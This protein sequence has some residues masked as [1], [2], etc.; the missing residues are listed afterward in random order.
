MKEILLKLIDKYAKLEIERCEEEISL[1]EEGIEETQKELTLSPNNEELLETLN[2]YEE[3][4][5]Y[6]SER[7]KLFTKEEKTNA[8][9]WFFRGLP[10]QCKS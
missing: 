2:F 1:A 6:Q 10:V 3:E 8:K 5:K 9:L 4:I 7:K